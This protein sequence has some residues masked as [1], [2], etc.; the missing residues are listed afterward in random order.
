[1]DYESV[2][3]ANDLPESVGPVVVRVPRWAGAMAGAAGAAVALG[4]GEIFDG[5]NRRLP[6][7]VAAVGAVVIDSA[8]AGTTKWAIGIFGENDKPAL[9]AGVAL[10]SLVLGASIGFKAI[11]H[12]WLALVGF[13]SFGVVGAL[14]V[15]RDPQAN[16]SLGWFVGLFAAVLGWLTYRLLLA[17]SVGPVHSL[18]GSQVPEPGTALVSPVR[19]KFERRRFMTAF[20]GASMVAVVGVVTGRR[21][22]ARS[23]VAAER[24]EVASR[25]PPVVADKPVVESGPTE[26]VDRFEDVTTYIT[27]NSEFYRIDT[28]LQ[29]PQIPPDSWV[30]RVTGMV[31]RPLEI[32]LEDLL[33]EELQE[34]T[35]TISCVSNQIGGDLAGNA[36]WTGVDLAGILERAGVQSGAEQVIGRSVDGWTAG[37]PT[38]VVD[39][40]RTAMIAIGMNGEPLPIVHG[41]PA[42]LIVAGLYGYVSATKWLSEIELTTWD[43]FDGYWIPRG[44]AKEGPIKITSRIDTPRSKT[45]RQDDGT[46]AIGGVAWAPDRGIGH[47]EIQVD[48]GDWLETELGGSESDETWVQWV[49]RVD[50][51]PGDHHVRVRALDLMGNP[52]PEGPASPGPNGAEGWHAVRL[53]V[54][55]NT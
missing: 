6:S 28:A 45:R 39:R 18:A 32:T 30:M 3:Q 53:S 26:I 21:L 34:R 27:P 43:A 19:L 1:M 16:V 14:A 24:L 41:F 47:V 50:L 25:F 36:V 54:L 10:L 8:D 42:R 37:F 35:V 33:G 17:F 2:S 15:A 49:L 40:E 9:V 48:D 13:V 51:E 46:V 55:D 7:L 12:R 44:W 22:R 5:A 38:S 23:S 31:D 4:V 20:G 52:Q 11:T 29:V